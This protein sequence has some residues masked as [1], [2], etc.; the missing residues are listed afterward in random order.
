M[1]IRDTVQDALQ[2]QGVPLSP[3]YQGYADTVIRALET[4]ESEIVSNLI[5]YAS[6]Q[7]LSRE[8]AL[9]AMDDCGLETSRQSGGD[10]EDPR[11]AEMEA[12][13]AAMQETLRQLRG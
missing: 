7:G 9:D 11:I 6:E 4:R 5:S 3:Q 10:G 13:M 2:K 8:T 1:N 12:Q